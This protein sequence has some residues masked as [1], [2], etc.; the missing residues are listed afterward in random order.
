M[1]FPEPVELSLVKN[2]GM[3]RKLSDSV[4]NDSLFIFHT[5][6]FSTEWLYKPL[7]EWENDEK[8]LEMKT[9][10]K[11]LKVT[12]DTAERGVKLVSDFSKVLTKN[13]DDRH[14]LLQVVERD[15]KVRP[16]V[17]KKT[18]AKDPTLM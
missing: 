15:R 18:L 3:N 8:F 16:N 5:H 17:T 14:N 1:G 6:G 9:W 4:D 10:V 11:T 12:N 2:I 7:S 13:S